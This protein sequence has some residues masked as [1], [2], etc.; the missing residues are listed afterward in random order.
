MFTAKDALY[1]AM[2]YTDKKVKGGGGGVIPIPLTVTENG[3]YTAEVGQAY[4]PVTVNVPDPRV[5]MDYYVG[6]RY[7]WSG[8]GNAGYHYDVYI[9]KQI[10]PELYFASYGGHDPLLP[11]KIRDLYITQYVQTIDSDGF[12]YLSM[13]NLVFPTDI[14]TVTFCWSYSCDVYQDVIFPPNLSTINALN[15]TLHNLTTEHPFVIPEGVTTINKLM[16]SANYYDDEHVEV[17]LPSTLLG[18]TNEL[19]LSNFYA[20]KCLAITPPDAVQLNFS[21][22]NDRHIYVPAESVDAYKSANG[23][24]NYAEYIEAIPTE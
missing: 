24:S 10:V 22:S 18:I 1:E 3:T 14:S 15:L 23:W 21:F 7:Y 12:G 4:N 16:L 13:R 5:S 17:V 6:D 11:D 20:I 19:N 9:T 8:S 2:A